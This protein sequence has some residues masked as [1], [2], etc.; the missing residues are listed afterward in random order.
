MFD[1]LDHCSLLPAPENLIHLRVASIFIILVGSSSGALFPV[2]ARR[3]SCLRV[4]KAV[5]EYASVFF[6][7]LKESNK[8]V[9]LA[10]PSTLGLVS[11]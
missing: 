4:P 10:S 8:V 9:V 1:E 7:N 3:S 11:S 6:F 5:F 2:L